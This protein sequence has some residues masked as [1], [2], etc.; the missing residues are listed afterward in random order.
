MGGLWASPA[1]T[2]TGSHRDNVAQAEMNLVH[3]WIGALLNKQAFGTS[4]G[5]LL[6]SGATACNADDSNQITSAGN[7]LDTF[8]GSGDNINSG[9]PEGNADPQGAQAFA[10]IAFWDNV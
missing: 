10:N 7:A 6:A 4:D 3:Q 1:K 5:G 2:S 8:N 9:I